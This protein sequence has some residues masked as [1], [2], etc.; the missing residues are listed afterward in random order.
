MKVYILLVKYTQST[1]FT[2]G[3]AHSNIKPFL[4]GQTR[5]EGEFSNVIRSLFYFC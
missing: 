5:G 3:I 2:A 4:C 1:Y